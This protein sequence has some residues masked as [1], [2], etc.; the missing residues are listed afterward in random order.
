MKVYIITNIGFPNGMAPANRI[1]CYARAIMNV[2]VDCDVLVYRRTERFGFVPRNIESKGIINGV[3]F[4][5]VGGTSLRGTNVI[6]RKLDDLRDKLTLIRLVLGKMALHDVLFIYSCSDTLFCILLCILAHVKRIKCVQDLC[7]LP[8]GTTVE[9]LQNKI[10]RF[11]E[12]RFL[13]PLL[14]GVVPISDALDEY[15][16]HF[17]SKRCKRIKIPIL[18]DFDEF[19]LED[20]SGSACV[21][22]IF[23]SGTLTEQKDGIL[24]I[25]EAFALAVE[26]TNVPIRLICT[27]KLEE[28][29]E[30]DALAALIEKYHLKDRIQFVGYLSVEELKDYLSRAKVVIINKYQTLQNKYCFSTKLGEYMA[31]GKAIIITDVGEAM[32]WMKDEENCLIV[33]PKN[34]DELSRAIVKLFENDSLR[35]KISNGAKAQ[36]QHFFDF[37]SYSQVLVEFMRSL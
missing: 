9:G 30:S 35:S 7:E 32:N 16:T 21:P 12:T 37:H 20:N 22:F 36:C 23:H 18:V 25:V 10:N 17:I 29:R 31:A 3:K 1:S 6:R 33:S 2:E 34:T 14:D 4:E 26:R 5:Y 13:L 15:S 11:F 28:S 27:G 8:Y 19:D 24:G